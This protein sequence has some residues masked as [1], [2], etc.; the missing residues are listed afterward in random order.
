MI[1]RIHYFK[2]RQFSKS[3]SAHALEDTTLFVF[4]DRLMFTGKAMCQCSVTNQF[5]VMCHILNYNLNTRD[6]NN[7]DFV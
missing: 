1:S 7:N 2:Q 5:R 6:E 4:V 3:M